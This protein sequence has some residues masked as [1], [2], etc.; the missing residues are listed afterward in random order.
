M[1]RNHSATG[2]AGATNAGNLHAV[3]ILDA[4]RRQPQR[5]DRRFPF[6][7]PAAEVHLSLAT[8]PKIS[9][10][11]N[12]YQGSILNMLHMLLF[13]LSVFLCISLYFSCESQSI[14]SAFE[15]FDMKTSPPQ[16]LDEV[17]SS[18]AASLSEA[19]GDAKPR[20]PWNPR[21]PARSKHGYGS[22]PL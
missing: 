9:G 5:C 11:M 18:A 7:W 2:A 4:T 19:R 15:D 21:H 16:P 17:A 20:I 1:Y 10:C 6:F 3:L 22:V 14:S 8:G 13:C 12:A